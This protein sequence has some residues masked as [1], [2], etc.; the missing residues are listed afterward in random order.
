MP[1]PVLVGIIFLLPVTGTGT[2]GAGAGADIGTG[3]SGYDLFRYM[4]T[5]FSPVNIKSAREPHYLEN[6]HGYFFVF[7][8][9]SWKKIEGKCLRSQALLWT[10]LR[11]LL[12]FTDNNF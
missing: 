11:A 1:L 4:Y 8:G 2:S 10:F 3:D 6:V 5:V 12:W 7:K 9:T